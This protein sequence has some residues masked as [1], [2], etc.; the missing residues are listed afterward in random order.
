LQH[1]GHYTIYNLC[2]RSYA[3][4]RFPSGQLVHSPLR[5]D[6]GPSLDTLLDLCSAILDYLSRQRTFRLF[7]LKYCSPMVSSGPL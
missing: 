2:E 7:Y 1:C 6:S 5:Q 3:A 4:S